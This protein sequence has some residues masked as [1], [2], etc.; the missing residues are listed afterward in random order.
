[1]TYAFFAVDN[2]ISKAVEI[3]KKVN[4]IERKERKERD[5]ERHQSFVQPGP[6]DSL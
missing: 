2:P 1:V 5:Q 6:T 4:R 3:L